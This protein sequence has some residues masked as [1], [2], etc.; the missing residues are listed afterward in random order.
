MSNQ[1]QRRASLWLLLIGM[2]L[3]LFATTYRLKRVSSVKD[4]GKYVLEQSGRVMTGKLSSNALQTIATY[5][6]TGLSGSEAY[7]WEVSKQTSGMKMKNVD[8]GDFLSSKSG[9]T[10][11]Y[12]ITTSA[13]ISF[14]TFQLQSDGTFIIKNSDNRSIGYMSA[15]DY[16]YKVYPLA[17]ATSPRNICIYQLVEET[18]DDAALQFDQSRQCIKLGES[19]SPAILNH[20]AGFDGTISYTSSNPDVATVDAATGAVSLVGIGSTRITASSAATANYQ[21]DETFYTLTVYEGDGTAAH[22][23]SIEALLSGKATIGSDVYFTG[24]IVGQHTNA[25]TL[26]ATAT[27]DDE[28]AIADTKGETAIHRVLPVTIASSLQTAYGLKSHPGL[29]GCRI[30][31]VGKTSSLYGLTTLDANTLAATRDVTIKAVHFATVGASYSLDFSGTGVSAYRAAVADDKVRLER[32][33]DGIVPAGQ[34]AV[35]YSDTPGTYAIPVTTAI[36]S[37]SDTGLSVSDGTTAK[38]GNIYVLASRSGEVCFLRWAQDSSL[39]KWQVYLD[40]GASA[41]DYLPFSFGEVT[42]IESVITVGDCPHSCFNM[43]G[44]RVTNPT[45]GLYIFNG[46]KVFIR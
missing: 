22:P 30:T 43:Q 13:Y 7:V 42:G 36:G 41:P 29:L 3:F 46:K 45:H 15:G 25:N 2:P 8:S 14:W 37:V 1:Y 9:N 18:S 16:R 44:Q 35:L 17:E 27:T 28:I 21:A 34:G 23:Y 24:Y 38:G 12:N 4:G 40:A 26:S 31:V 5:K 10:G 19:F 33:S 11:L 6:A 39:P 20:A 32:I